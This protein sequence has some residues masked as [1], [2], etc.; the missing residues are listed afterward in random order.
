VTGA[1]QASVTN[2]NRKQ[3]AASQGVAKTAIIVWLHLQAE[4]LNV[5][6]LG[7]TYSLDT[8]LLMGDIQRLN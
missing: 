2:N 6:A 8:G 1:D 5:P 3:A 7:K 4:R